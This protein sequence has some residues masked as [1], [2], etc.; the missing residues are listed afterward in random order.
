[1]DCSF[2]LGSITGV[3]GTLAGVWLT[4]HLTTNEKRKIDEA[5]K[6]ILKKMLKDMPEGT[7]WRELS[8]LSSVIGADRDETTRLLIAVGARGSE[9]GNDVWALICN[10]PL[11]GV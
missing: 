11:G 4:H 5:R 1:M 6:A 10:K 2:L 3:I 9:A 7:E 8:T